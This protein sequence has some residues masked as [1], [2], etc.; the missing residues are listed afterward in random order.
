[1]IL[2]GAL[3]LERTSDRLPEFVS[4]EP[5]AVIAVDPFQGVPFTVDGERAFLAHAYTDPP[6]EDAFYLL[7]EDKAVLLRHRALPPVTVERGL[8]RVRVMREFTG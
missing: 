1:M 5:A 7:V 6:D 4:M 2:F 3:V 8:W